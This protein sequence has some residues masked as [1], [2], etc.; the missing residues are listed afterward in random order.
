MDRGADLEKV[1]REGLSKEVTCV[2][3][4][5]EGRKGQVQRP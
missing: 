5:Q 3:D 2:Q 1:A 4:L